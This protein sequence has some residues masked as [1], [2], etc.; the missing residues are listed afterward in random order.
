[1]IE[2]WKAIPGY[3]G[4]YEVS[5]LGRIR[6]VP[7]K[8][9]R[10]NCLMTLQNDPRTGRLIVQLRKNNLAS[11]FYVSRLVCAA[12]HN[13]PDGK[14]CVDHIN[15]N[16]LDNRACN[17]RWCTQKE[18]CNYPLAAKHRRQAREQSSYAFDM[19]EAHKARMCAVRCVETA[20]TYESQQQAA[21]AFGVHRSSI[22]KAIKTNGVCCG[23]H[24]IG[25]T[26]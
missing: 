25:V 26:K 21:D 12:F 23:M 6:S 18:N 4:L 24:F 7:R 5:S 3:E 11:C 10:R 14:D 16:P 20:K 22:N 17:L 13:K 2:V 9:M 19:Q 8:H 1:M 15:G